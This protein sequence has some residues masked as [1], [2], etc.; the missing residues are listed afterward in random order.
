MLTMDLF[1]QA[2]E[3]LSS[4]ATKTALIKTPH[5]NPDAEVYLKTEN[6]QYTGSF[7][8]RGAYFKI[9]NLTE[10]EKSKGVVACSAGNHAQGVA[11]AA[12][13]FGVDATI[14]IP[15]GA[16]IS[17]IENTRSYGAK[18]VL[19]KGV[20]DDAYK[21]ATEIVEKEGKTMIHPF[22][23]EYVMAG[24]GTI[25]MEICEQLPD[26][27]IILVPIG[28]GG[29]A[30]GISFAAKHIN[31]NCKVYG[32][33]ASGAPSMCKSISENHIC[34]L[35]SVSTIADG[36]AVKRPGDKTYE[37]CKEYLDGVVT[38]SESEIATAILTL[39]EK[40][41]LVAEGAGAV[42][43]AAA[44][45]NKVDVKGKKVVCVVSGGNID[46]T[47]LSRIIS[48]GLAKT[49]RIA[50]ISVEMNDKPG[51]LVEFLKIIS[52]L[53]AN[54]ISID[55]NRTSAIGEIA[56]CI[57]N[58][59]LETKNKEHGEDIIKTISERGYHVV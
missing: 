57:V 24:Q 3:A 27:D 7:K 4:V 42:S 17:K 38:V 48:K 2:R 37:V 22:N 16:P 33:E 9:A 47:I 23:D 50:S 30:S 35:S 12:K 52:E 49:G 21:V 45:F 56:R 6:L 59:L 14:C 36:I 41:K 34:E 19:C 1:Q 11:L 31:P 53:G 15:E 54:V 10:E 29:L 5:I 8:L 40:N 32:V 26:A 58:I 46:V 13:K 39:M 18:V 28:G 25:A 55:H 43:I 51:A 20:Y 44:M